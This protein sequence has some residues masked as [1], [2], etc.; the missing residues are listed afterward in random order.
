MQTGRDDPDRFR[1]WRLVAV[2]TALAVGLALAFRLVPELDLTVS[3]LFHDP[4]TGFSLAGSA[5]WDGV[6]QLNKLASFV[7]VTTALVLLAAAQ[8]RGQTADILARRYWAVVLLLYL[9]GPGL[10]VNGLLKR[11]YGRARPVQI[12]AFGGDGPFTAAWQVSDYCHSGCSFV[13]AEVAVGTALAVGLGIG[14]FW[15]AGR[16]V[17]RWFRALSLSALGLLLLTAVQRVGSGRHFLSDV[18][19]A[20]LLVAALGV[21]LACLLRPRASDQPTGPAR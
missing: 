10:L 21:A 17:A 20:A 5:A 19:F 6:V 15:F 1:C 7:F 16:P 12:E 3:R 2:L 11:V 8:L 14:A 18:I 4:A 9:L 13:S